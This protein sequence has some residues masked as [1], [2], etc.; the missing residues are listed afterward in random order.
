MSW[1][2]VVVIVAAVVGA[3]VWLRREL[4]KQ[5][6]RMMANG[7]PMF[8]Q[9]PAK[10]KDIETRL[11]ATEAKADEA[12]SAAISATAVAGSAADRKSRAERV[13]SAPARTREAFGRRL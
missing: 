6:G 7:C 3:A 9:V 12:V 11:G 1:G 13:E 8:D 10:L 5:V 4:S 2:Q